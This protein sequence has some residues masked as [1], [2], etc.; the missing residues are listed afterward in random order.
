[1]DLEKAK[2]VARAR[3][4]SGDKLVN[5]MTAIK[6]AKR[7]DDEVMDLQMKVDMLEDEIEYLNGVLS[8]GD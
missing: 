3:E 4:W 8:R 5:F 7:L 2:S 6:A 1:M